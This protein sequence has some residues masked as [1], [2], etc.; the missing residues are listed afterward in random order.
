[1]RTKKVFLS[2]SILWTLLLADSDASE[3]IRN[4]HLKPKSRI[5]TW[6]SLSATFSIF[7][8]NAER[9]NWAVCENSIGD[10]NVERYRVWRNFIHPHTRSDWTHAAMN[11]LHFWKEWQSN[12]SIEQSNSTAMKEIGWCCN[13]HW[14]RPCLCHLLLKPRGLGQWLCHNVWT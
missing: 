9:M 4:P 5:T 14:T 2:W 10:H 6:L 7:H 12:W 8:D 1:M 11:R 3:S 13:C